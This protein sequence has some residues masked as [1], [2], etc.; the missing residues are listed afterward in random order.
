MDGNPEGNRFHNA[1]RERTTQNNDASLI[2]IGE[3]D[4]RPLRLKDTRASQLDQALLHSTHVEDLV[5]DVGPLS[6]DGNYEAL[7][8]S[9]RSSR[10]LQRLRLLRDKTRRV[11]VLLNPAEVCP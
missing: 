5:T 1:I 11:V 8:E 6:Q 4:E 7:L 3:D 10:N 2:R 9:I